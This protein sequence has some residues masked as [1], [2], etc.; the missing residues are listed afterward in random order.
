MHVYIVCILT[1]HYVVHHMV[2]GLLHNNYYSIR[3][4]LRIP[5]NRIAYALDK[6]PHIEVMFCLPH[7]LVYPNTK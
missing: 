1:T 5:L 4:I 3:Y 7:Y 6:I 2:W